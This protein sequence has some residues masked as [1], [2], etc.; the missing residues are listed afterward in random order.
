MKQLAIIAAALV[1]TACARNDTANQAD[2]AGGA[3]SGTA[4]DTSAMTGTGTMGTD[5]SRMGRDTTRR[6]TARTGTRP[7]R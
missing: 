6:D 1:I 3:L 4:A 7:P 5:T 2:T